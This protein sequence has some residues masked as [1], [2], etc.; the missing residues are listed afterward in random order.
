MSQ[1]PDKPIPAMPLATPTDAEIEAWA[2]LPRDEQVRRYQELFKHL[3]C[4]NFTDDTADEILAAACQRGAYRLTA[5]ED[6]DLAEADNEIARGEIASPEEVDA[7]WKK[8]GR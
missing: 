8:H 6:A 5:E 2:A 1:N 4:S 7:M 3:D